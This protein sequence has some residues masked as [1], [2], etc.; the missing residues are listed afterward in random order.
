MQSYLQEN[1][2]SQATPAHQT[3]NTSQLQN[4]LAGYL[5][6]A[7]LLVGWYYIFTRLFM[8]EYSMNSTIGILATPCD[9]NGDDLL[10][11]NTPPPPRDTSSKDDWTPFNSRAEFRLAEFVFTE[12]EM[13]ERNSNT[14]M[15]IIA[16]LL[17]PHD[18]D[19]PFRDHKELLA[20]IDAIP[21]GDIPWKSF[22]AKY[23]GDFPSGEVPEWMTTEYEVHYRDPHQ[24]VL[25]MLANPD[26]DGH[27]DYMPFQ[28]FANE[29]RRWSNFMSGNWAWR[30]AVSY[31]LN[32][33]KLKLISYTG[34]IL[35]VKTSQ[36]MA[37]CSFL[38]F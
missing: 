28:E 24:V 38:L 9:E 10:D 30:Q 33:L 6:E 23:Q 26:F 18:E 15:E 35:L 8:F 20:T 7:A 1:L 29:K 19:P 11:P 3:S 14:L 27:F 36:L 31:C 17:R 13:S 25:N 37:P 22:K 2:G 16:A 12:T 21:Y 4:P 5:P 34:R 32:D